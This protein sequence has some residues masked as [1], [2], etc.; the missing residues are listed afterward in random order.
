MANHKKIITA[1]LGV[2]LFLFGAG[3]G[4]SAETGHPKEYELK[5]AFIYN[6]TKFIEWPTNTLGGTN[7]PFVIAV[8]GNSPCIAELEQ[9]AKEKKVNGRDLVINTVK[10]PEAATRAQALFIP[11]SEEARLKDW[12]VKNPG[13][14]T[15]GESDAF[16]R[17]GG[18]INFILEGEKIRFEI[19]ME[20]VEAARLKISAQMQK[21]AK[22]VR[23]KS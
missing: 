20:P 12:L 9:I 22:T 10:T 4:N 19:N 23:R 1:M 7:E 3:K 6:F 18:M 15:I 13:L 16:I 21:L 14:L 17:Q 5:A 11:A 8:A 2:A